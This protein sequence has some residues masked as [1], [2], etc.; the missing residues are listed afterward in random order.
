MLKN[1]LLARLTQLF[2]NRKRHLYVAAL[3]IT[4]D[5]GAAEDAVHDAMLAVSALQEEPDDLAAYLFKTVRNKALH[6]SK[7]LQRFTTENDL[8]EFVDYGSQPPEQQVLTSQIMKQLHTLNMDQQ[9]VLIMKLFAGLTFEEISEITGSS[10]N[11][12]A[13]W[14]RRGISK[15][16]ERLNEHAL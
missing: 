13:S 11:T 8:S 7:Q 6:G 2:E 14:Y 12:V 3:A 16:K 4:K 9:Q 10:S 15:L 5:R 1:S